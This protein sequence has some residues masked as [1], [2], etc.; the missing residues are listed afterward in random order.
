MR[1]TRLRRAFVLAGAASAVALATAAAIQAGSRA[2]G[3][4]SADPGVA[5][6]K[7][8]IAK[9]S[10]IPKFTLKA[11]AF[12]ASKAKGKTIFNIPVTE[13]VPFVKTIDDSMAALA[14]RLGIN[15]VNFPNP[16]TPTDWINGM[17]QAIS[18]KVD[19]IILQAGID[20][21]VL[22]PQLKAAKAAGIPVIN[23]H[24]YDESAPVPPNIT[25]LVPAAFNRGARLEADW[26]IADTNGKANVLMILSREIVPSNGIV[27]SWQDEFKKHCPGCKVSKVV[28]VP[29]PKWASGIQSEVQSALTADP[30]INYIM[31]TYDSMNQF[32][33]PGIVAVGKIGKVHAVGYNGT[34]FVL[35]MMQDQDVVRVNISE[36]LEWIAWANIDQAMRV[37]LGLKPLKTEKMAMRV[38]TRANVKE[39][40]VPPVVNKGLGNAYIAGYEKLWGLAK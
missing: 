16:G 11:P 9:W 33:V 29:V 35:K 39:A 13:A 7:A 38:F 25:A 6:A 21:A 19:L 23:T 32:V 31:P 17:N 5:Y 3:A 36:N 18:R 37:M 30:T 2:P 27:A 34:P 26:V 8:Q 15:F 24:L 4:P 28:N 10:V 1:G 12:D 14:K 22:Q 20:A 40:G